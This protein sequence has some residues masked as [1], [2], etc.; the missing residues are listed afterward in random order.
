MV[1]LFPSKN[2]DTKVDVYPKYLESLHAMYG[3]QQPQ[4]VGVGTSLHP[5]ISYLLSI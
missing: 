5:V 1:N 2:K 3:T 4:A